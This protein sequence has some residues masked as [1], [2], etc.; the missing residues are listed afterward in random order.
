MLQLSLEAQQR[1]EQH[2]N[3]RLAMQVFLMEAFATP[4]A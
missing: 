2:V 1:V 3:P 4:P